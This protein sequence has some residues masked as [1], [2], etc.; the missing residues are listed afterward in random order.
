MEPPAKNQLVHYQQGLVSVRPVVARI[1]DDFVPVLNRD[2]AGGGSL[3]TSTRPMLDLPLLLRAYVLY[4]HSPSRYCK[5]CST[6]LR[7]LV[8]NDPAAGWTTASRRRWRQGLT[9]VH[10]S[11][12]RKHFVWDRGCI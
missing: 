10:F 9:L 3:R 4:E 5:S 8:L 2:E 1:P 12:Q 6:S 7:A 11:A